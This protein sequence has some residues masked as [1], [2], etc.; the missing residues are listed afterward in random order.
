MLASTSPYWPLNHGFLSI[1][2]FVRSTTSDNWRGDRATSHLHT[3]PSSKHAASK[4][5]LFISCT[6]SCRTQYSSPATSVVNEQK[7]AHRETS[8]QHSQTA[9]E[10]KHKHKH[11]GS[12]RPVKMYFVLQKDKDLRCYA[13]TNKQNE[14]NLAHP[15]SSV[16][17]RRSRPCILH[18]IR[19]SSHS[20]DALLWWQM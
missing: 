17:E 1:F 5:L 8:R 18:P 14:A 11:I 9:V 3:S 4:P 10:K 7:T 20:C 19:L 13:G 2:G 15:T 12:K 6:T 16:R